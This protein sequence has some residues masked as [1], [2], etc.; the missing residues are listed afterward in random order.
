MSLAAEAYPVIDADGGMVVLVRR[1]MEPHCLA[2][3]RP[4]Y[5]YATLKTKMLVYTSSQAVKAHNSF[6]SS[7]P[8]V[9]SCKNT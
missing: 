8:S 5:L 4:S 3:S 6:A 2:V 1:R 7:V 9:P